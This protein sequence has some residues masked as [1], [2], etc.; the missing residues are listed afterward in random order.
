MDMF[1]LEG[2]NAV[3]IGGA[4]GIGQAV[5][6]GLAQAGAK[7]AIASRNEES[8]KK[9]VAQIKEETGLDVMYYTV[10]A[11]DEESMA[12]LAKKANEEMGTVEILVNSQGLNKKFPAEEFPV[13]I[14]RQ[15]LD[16]N[17]VG[18][19]LACKHFGQYMIKNGYGKI[20]NVSSVRSKIATK[21]PGNVGYCSTKGAVDMLTKQFAS[22]FGPHGITVNAFGPTVTM[23]PMMAPVIE[24]RGGQAYLDSLAAALP[25]RK[26]AT[27]EDVVGT[28]IFLAS[29]ASDFMTGNILYPDGGLTCVG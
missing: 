7:V 19:M 12:E 18:M 10:D 2:K 11:T 22:E 14:F 26:Y 9:A 25:M 5:A 15:M 20:V 21:T 3:V 13:D 23:T 27:P 17:V 4:G 8:L 16:V 6:Q 24:Q 29:H 1:S 28:A